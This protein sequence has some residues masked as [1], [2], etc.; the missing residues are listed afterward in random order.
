MKIF[1][2]SLKTGKMKSVDIKNP[3]ENKAEMRTR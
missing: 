3:H 1:M 2:N